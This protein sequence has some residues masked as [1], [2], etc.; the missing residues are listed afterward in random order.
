MSRRTCYRASVSLPRRP[1]ETVSAALSE[2]YW[3]PAEAVGLFENSPETWSV[4][5]YFSE[6]PD[7]D[8]LRRFLA[9]HGAGDVECVIE[10][11]PDA[12]WVAITQE[13]LHP[14]RAGRFIVHG[15]HD[16][17][18]VGRGRWTI[19]IDAGQAFGTAHHGST[20]GCVEALDAIAKRE[21]FSRILD[22][23]TGTGVLAIA[24]ARLWRARVIASDV[25]PV[26]AATASANAR[27]NGTGSLV[28]AV[29]AAGLAH[30]L[31]RAGAPYDLVIANILARPLIGLASP[32]AR[33]VRTGGVTV[34][35]G[36]T[37][38]Q[39]ARVAAA[40]RAA[41]F[42]HYRRIVIDEWVT[43]T[44]RRRAGR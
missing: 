2:L 41:G 19:E 39:A 28:T 35:S 37:R 5:A 29:T 10:A 8:R 14:V 22:L 36:I 43:L 33:M 38:N 17:A 40:Y 16:R 1:A 44:L 31:I 13:R 3:P 21:R 27:R 23:G 26:A 30:P 7:A 32:L 15:S 9:E 4:D 18:R 34:L 12:D 24:A 6:P 11:V 42:A 25:D 20:R